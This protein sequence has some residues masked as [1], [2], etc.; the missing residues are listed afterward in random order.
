[1]ENEEED[2]APDGRSQPGVDKAGLLG[3]GPSSCGGWEDG[4]GGDEEGYEA[5]YEKTGVDMGG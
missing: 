5:G 3:A 1:M 2:G 4:G